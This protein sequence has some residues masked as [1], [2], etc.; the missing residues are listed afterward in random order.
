MLLSQ[1]QL[2][3]KIFGELLAWQ[4]PQGWAVFFGGDVCKLIQLHQHLN[5]TADM[6]RCSG[7]RSGR[8]D[9]DLFQCGSVLLWRFFDTG[10]VGGGG[11]DGK[12]GGNMVGGRGWQN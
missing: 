12:V 7:G 2:A 11:G 1:E 9:G 3:T 5:L 4:V 6:S 8:R 10:T